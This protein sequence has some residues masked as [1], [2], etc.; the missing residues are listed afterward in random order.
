MIGSIDGTLGHALGG[1]NRA[2]D[3]VDGAA[4]R[5]AGGEVEAEPVI[6]LLT[7]ETAFGANAAVVRTAD[8]MQ[9]RLLD[10]LA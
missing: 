4:R 6:D 2:V 8:Q 7:A 5:I 1:L 9:D 3:Q 10:I